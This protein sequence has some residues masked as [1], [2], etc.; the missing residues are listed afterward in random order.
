[1][2]YCM[3]Y[4]YNINYCKINITHDLIYIYYKHIMYVLL[5]Y[6]N[7]IY[8]HGYII[9]QYKCHCLNNL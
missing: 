4:Y 6:N 2:N 7:K 8:N 5:R 1:M 3:L 9:L